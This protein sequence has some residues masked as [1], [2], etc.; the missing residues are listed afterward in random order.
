MTHGV[1]SA[2]ST[3]YKSSCFLVSVVAKALEHTV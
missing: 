1:L 3:D 2:A